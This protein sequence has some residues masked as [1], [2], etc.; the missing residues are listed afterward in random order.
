MEILKK[1]RM[2]IY[3]NARPLDMARWN[4]L[5][6]KG[7]KEAVIKYL[8]S[9]QNADGGFAHALEPDC[10]N[11]NT[12]PMQTWAATKIIKEIN[13]QDKT[14]PLITG[15]IRYLSCAD[16][17]DGH[18]W[19][20]LNNVPTNNDF[21]HAPWWAYG[22]DKE[23][24]YNPTASLIGFMLKYADK[25]SSAYGLACKL[26]Q[27]AYLNFKQKFPLESM[28]EA[29]CFVELYEYLKECEI[30]YPVNLAEFKALLQQQIKQTIT[31]DTDC[32][33][34][35]YICKPS[36]F[37]SGK[38]SDF[39]FGNEDICGFERNFIKQTQNADGTWNITWEWDAFPQQW[40]VS[41]NWWKADI[42][43]RN[44]AY[45]KAFEE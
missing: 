29:A 15:I 6:E 7:E 5:F 16:K 14:H 39:Y 28:H 9:Y 23:T 33:S 34:T 20:G 12:T 40:A 41:K 24:S 44:L 11:E 21:P 3:K 4:Y 1:S 42:I 2:F 30:D 37:I 17:F 38:K 26:T 13:L 36:L 43:I 22:Q 10:W 27:E 31:Y 45:V 35:A 19:S 32:W 8:K 25:K 18:C